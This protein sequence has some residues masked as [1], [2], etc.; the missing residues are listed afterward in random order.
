MAHAGACVQEVAIY[1]VCFTTLPATATSLHKQQIYAELVGFMA[2]I[3]Y[4][5]KG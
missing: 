4:C 2:G 3:A 1:R 5:Y